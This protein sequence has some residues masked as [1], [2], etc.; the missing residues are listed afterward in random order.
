MNYKQM[1]KGNIRKVKQTPD[2]NG[3]QNICNFVDLLGSFS[4]QDGRI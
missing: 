1:Q 4:K 2:L 3:E